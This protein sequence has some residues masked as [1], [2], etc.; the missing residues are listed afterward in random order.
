MPTN[1]ITVKDLQSLYFTTNIKNLR[2]ILEKGILSRSA[3][4][5]QGL[6]DSKHD[7]S[8]EGVQDRRRSKK[9]SSP[10]TGIRRKLHDYANLYFQ[11]HNAFL[12]VVQKEISRNELCVIRVNS[13]ILQDKENIAVLTTKNAACTKAKFFAPA[14]WVPSPFT[15]RALTST[16]LSGLDSTAWVGPYKFRDSKQSRQS[17]ALVPDKIDPSYFDSILVHNEE[18]QARIE[19]LLEEMGVTIPVTIHTTLFAS[20]K[21]DAFSKQLTAQADPMNPVRLFSNLQKDID[22]EATIKSEVTIREEAESDND[23]ISTKKRKFC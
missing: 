17:E 21:R 14:A 6:Y 4:Q 16:R 22:S 9:F 5:A 10:R 8:S 3:V 18:V 2:S 19:T 13:K 1:N 20:P 23:S 11:P 12:V 15:S 7:I